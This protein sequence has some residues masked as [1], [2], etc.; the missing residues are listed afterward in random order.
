MTDQHARANG[1]RRLG[2]T[3]IDRSELLLLR[4]TTAQ[5][6]PAALASET[7]EISHS[8]LSQVER[9]AQGVSYRI[10]RVYEKVLGI[11]VDEVTGCAS[12]TGW[13]SGQMSP[14]ERQIMM[15]QIAACAVAG[16]EILSG[17]N[18]NDLVLQAGPPRPLDFADPAAIATL[19]WLAAELAERGEPARTVAHCLLGWVARPRPNLQDDDID[20]RLQ[21][22]VSRLARRAAHGA[23]TAGRQEAA[24]S[25]Y[26]LALLAASAGRDPNLRAGV[27]ADLA[28]QQ[29]QFGYREDALAVLRL[30]EGDERLGE[31][32]RVRLK[33]VR[34]A[35]QAAVEDGPV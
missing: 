18:R 15:V 6:A 23:E 31:D 13:C 28:Q 27:L 9:G 32:V 35:A 2:G 33:A 17:G 8:H 5:I 22:V 7:G 11:K 1:R 10:I 30:A 16:G 26:L 25:L 34:G 14:G 24:R 3:T 19:E 4:E 20:C 29:A 12:A 21:A